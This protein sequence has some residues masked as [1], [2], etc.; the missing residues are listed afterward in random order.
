MSSEITITGASDDL[1]LVA[2]SI[3]EEFYA[4]ESE[5]DYLAFSDGTVL[6]IV[7]DEDGIWRITRVVKGSAVYKHVP[8]DVEADTFDVVTLKGDVSWV[9]RGSDFV[10]V[11]KE[12]GC[13]LGQ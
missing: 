13:R 11:G 10:T 5:S 4:H 9:L 1:I 7:Y 6:S 8:G 12:E 2:G 3:E